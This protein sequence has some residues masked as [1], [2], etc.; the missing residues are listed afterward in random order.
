MSQE[1]IPHETRQASLQRLRQQRRWT[2]WLVPRPVDLV[3][4]LLYLS[5]P[6]LFFY[7]NSF[8]ALKQV[9][10]SPLHGEV[11]SVIEACS[12]VFPWPQE[13]TIIVM[14][15]ALLAIDRLE[16]W[17]YREATPP[18]VAVCMFIARLVC[19]EIAAQMD[20]FRFSPF[21][22]LMVPFFA[23]LYF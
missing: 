4:S 22:Y 19:I 3:T 23:T 20:N 10:P 17:F 12:C 11:H 16:Y 21:L 14:M 13:V 7:Y 6:A 9:V 8:V 15:L 2:L 1:S 5:I 18:K